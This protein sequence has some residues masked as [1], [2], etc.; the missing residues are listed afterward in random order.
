MR[1]KILRRV[2]ASTTLKLAIK[3]ERCKCGGPA[4]VSRTHDGEIERLCLGCLW[5]QRFLAALKTAMEG[6]V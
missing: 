4:T 6:E 1:K 3:D 5:Q 2:S